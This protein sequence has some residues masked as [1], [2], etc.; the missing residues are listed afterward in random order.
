MSRAAM[1]VAA[2]RHPVATAVGFLAISL[3]LQVLVGAAV[4]VTVP[5]PPPLLAGWIT[6][7][8]H[9]LWA[10]GALW[11]LGWVQT[12]GFNHPA[13]WRRRRIAPSAR[14]ALLALTRA[15]IR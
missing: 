1:R 10:L 7:V 9:S 6:I 12:A 4:R 13:A 2:R 15:M 8:V 3:V 14:R 11:W 5:S